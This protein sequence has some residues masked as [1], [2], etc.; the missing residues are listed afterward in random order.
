ML[1]LPRNPWNPSMFA[2][3]VMVF[4]FIGPIAAPAPQPISTPATQSAAPG[5]LTG[6][7]TF[8]GT[9]APAGVIA[10]DAVVYLVG[11]G[12]DAGPAATGKL[13][14]A[15]EDLMFSPHV[16]TV[17]AGN[18]VE[19][20]NDDAVMHNVNTVSRMNRPTNRAQLAGMSFN[21]KL[22]QPEIVAVKCDVHSQ[23]SAYIAVVPNRYYS[24]PAADGSYRIP[25]VPAG[26]YQLVGWHEK[27]GTVTTDIEVTDGQTVTAS[28]NFT[29]N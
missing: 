19:V 5:N 8:D 22:R 7:V 18:E 26:T 28:I 9:A 29:S 2:S 11:E 27:Y 3:A 17:V 25:N 16:L 4:G 15:Q 1:K 14:L 10:S 24:S 20:R 12:L 13:V 6:T 23:M 21:L